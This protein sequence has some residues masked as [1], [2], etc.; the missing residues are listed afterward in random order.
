MI[1]ARQ[2]AIVI[3]EFELLAH[4]GSTLEK[5]TGTPNVGVDKENLFSSEI[6]SGLTRADI[7]EQFNHLVKVEAFSVEGEMIKPGKRYDV[8]KTL[9]NSATLYEDGLLKM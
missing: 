8:A 4:L 1:T 2:I 5:L 7:E 9:A 3:C 6:R